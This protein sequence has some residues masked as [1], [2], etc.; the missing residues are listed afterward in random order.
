MKKLFFLTCFLILTIITLT[1]SAYSAV[2]F[3]VRLGYLTRLNTTEENFQSIIESANKA[4]DW[5]IFAPHHEKFGVKFYDSLQIMQ[6]A[7][8]AN[9]IDEMVLPEMT[10]SYLIKANPDYSV[11]CASRAQKPMSLA[12]G[13]RKDL[14]SQ[15]LARKF[16]TA[17]KAMEED[18]TLANLQGEYI[19]STG[20]YRPVK[21]PKFPGK[22]TIRVAVTGDMPP[23]D[24][25]AEDGEPAGFNT[26]LLA[27][28]SKRLE[29]NIELIS[30]NSGSRT[31][32]LTSGRADVVFWYETS[33]T[34]DYN[35]DAP[36]G[37]LL[38]EPYYSWNTFL[39]INLNNLR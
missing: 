18:F 22:E 14:I 20:E 1:T 16:N 33:K 35:A 3:S 38:S 32:A 21:L 5:S 13:F 2:I 37:I 25:I 10:G 19:N 34:F 7:L 4:N 12:F 31:A 36:D 8:N 39:H 28:I 9:E 26:A 27:E 6:M 24:F 15:A 17:I 30:I 11:C 29:I 23:I